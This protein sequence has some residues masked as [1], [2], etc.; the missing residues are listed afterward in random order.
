MNHDFEQ[1]LASLN[2]E[3]V[4]YLLI[5][6]YAVAIHAQPRA[7]KDLDI[8]IRCDPAN[9]LAVWRALA[10]FGAS[11]EGVTPDYVAQPG[12]GF[13]MGVPPY[14]IEVITRI[15]GIEFA[16]ARRRAIT[17]IIKRTRN[18]GF[19]S[20]P[21]MTSL[22]TNSRL[23]GRKTWPTWPLCAKP[24]SSA[25]TP[26]LNPTTATNGST[27]GTTT[28]NT[29]PSHLVPPRRVSRRVMLNL[30]CSQSIIRDG[31]LHGCC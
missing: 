22:P 11:L 5:G 4:D 21:P 13:R 6:G 31:I 29:D 2:A 27:S 10:R 20:S 25:G 30:S 14:M 8:F 7:T 26:H 23:G 15:A 18:Y 12:N 3:N 28:W 19:P 9:A 1:F 16:D 24:R 17:D